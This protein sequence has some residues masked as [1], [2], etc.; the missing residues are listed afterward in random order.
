LV[1]ITVRTQLAFFLLFPNRLSEFIA[2]N[3]SS[4]GKSTLPFSFDDSLND[5][6]AMAPFGPAGRHQAAQTVGADA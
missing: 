5:P 4:V 2:V 6:L 1:S 3:E